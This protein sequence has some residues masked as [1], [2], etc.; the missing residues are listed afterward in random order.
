[1]VSFRLIGC[2][3][4]AHMVANTVG[5]YIPRDVVVDRAAA[6]SATT[7]PQITTFVTSIPVPTP[8]VAAVSSALQSDPNVSLL[9]K[10]QPFVQAA[11]TT[12][13]CEVLKL[14]LGSAKVDT[15]PVD[16]SLVELNWLVYIPATQPLSLTLFA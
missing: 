8:Q 3:L 13:A 2:V 10:G 1:M 9:L 14:I 4:S 16:T 15:K 5:S 7:D 6:A 11:I 12:V